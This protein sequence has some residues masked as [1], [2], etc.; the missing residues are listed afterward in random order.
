MN[1]FEVMKEKFTHPLIDLCTNKV[2]SDVPTLLTYI[3]YIKKNGNLSQI[4]GLNLTLE[5]LRVLNETFNDKEKQQLKSA[6]IYLYLEK[7]SA[8]LFEE[9]K[10]LLSKFKIYSVVVNGLVKYSTIEPNE[11]KILDSRLWYEYLKNLNKLTSNIEKSLMNDVVDIEKKLFLILCSRIVE[12]V[13]YDLNSEK[14][15]NENSKW[16]SMDATNEIVG[17]IDGKCVCR[18]YAGILRDA[19]EILE[20]NAIVVCGNDDRSGHAWNQVM[21]D[22]KWYNVDLTW[23]AENI[24][25]KVETYWILK[26]D[27][28]FNQY[29]ISTNLGNFFHK[30]FTENR[31]LENNCDLSVSGDVIKQYLYLEDVMKKGWL[32]N[33]LHKVNSVIGRRK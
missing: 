16:H 21:L 6:H 15:Y 8:V 18:G 1:E 3:S 25:K 30:S 22:G 4:D 33:V 20:I 9:Y 29:G 2:K 19:C 5:E 17:L 26:S 12:N 10:M 31:S 23:D 24:L 27:D 13:T 11:T 28:D 32:E 14:N 7:P